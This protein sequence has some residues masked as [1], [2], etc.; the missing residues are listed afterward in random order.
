MSTTR[1]STFL[2]KDGMAS[3]L[4]E[5]LISIIP[6]IEESRGCESCQVL[7]S[8]DD[9][10]EFVVIEIWDSAA[11]HQAS[12]KSIPPEKLAFVMAMLASPPSGTYYAA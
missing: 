2:A 8:Q 5:F 6:L 4:R 11:A 7:Q 10:N 1:I 3:N 12:V 9:A